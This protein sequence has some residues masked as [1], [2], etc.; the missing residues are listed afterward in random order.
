MMEI[1]LNPLKHLL[2]ITVLQKI[3]LFIMKIKKNTAVE[4]LKNS[5]PPSKNM[6]I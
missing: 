4:L 5:N 6:L 1:P 2:L 3:P